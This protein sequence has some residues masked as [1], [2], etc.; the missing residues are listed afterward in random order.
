MQDV[1]MNN[2]VKKILLR[3]CREPGYVTI[4]SI[5]KELEV[6]TKTV[7]RELAEVESWLESKGCNLSKKTGTG[8]KVNG[9]E[10]RRKTILAL[11]MGEKEENFYSPR[12]RQIV[13][14]SELLQNQ[15][16]VK[17]YNFA[18]ILKVTEGTISN[19]L[20]KIEQWFAKQELTLV[21]RPGLGVYVEGPESQLRKA[22]VH[23]IYENIEEDQLLGIIRSSLIQS[24]E[25]TA[26]LES[27]TR[28]RLLNLI[29]KN[30]IHKLEAS[31]HEAQEKMGHR[32]AD[33]AYVGLIVHLAL[34]VQRIRKKEKITIDSEF[35]KELKEYPEYTIAGQM[36]E[37]IAQNFGI[38]LPE[39]EI[40]YITMHIKG[41]KNRNDYK[42]DGKPIGNFELVKLSKEII[43]IAERETGQLL[44]HN[45]KLLVGLVNHL[46]PS[47]SR[48]KMGLDIRN[49]FVE[50]IKAFYPDLVEISRRCAQAVEDKLGLPMP[51][52]EIAYIA[53]HLGAAMETGTNLPKPL[54]RCA[55]ACSTG[56]GTSRLL[57]TKLEKEFDNLQIVELISTIHLEEGRLQEQQVDFIISTVS[58]EPCTL[59][60]VTVNPLLFEEDKNK[61]LSLMRRLVSKMATQP[62]K[63]RLQLK[64]RLLALEGYSQA[65]IALLDGFF[66]LEAQEAQQVEQIIDEVSDYLGEDRGQAAQLAQALKDREEK[67]G[68]FITGHGLVLL[69]C[70]SS[71]VKQ[72]CFGAVQIRESL[73]GINGLGETEAVNLAVIMTAPEG[74]GR[75]GMET[76]G[77][78]SKMLLERPEFTQ[79]LRQGSRQEASME[80]TRILEEFYRMKY[81]KLMEGYT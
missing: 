23:F 9:S 21:R 37:R 45:E 59:P 70:R 49:P 61:I 31:I 80:V 22:M 42:K 35:L 43:R 32:L 16:P 72:L 48:L 54:Y 55:V 71:A 24:S 81:K 77:Y 60:V 79:L 27:T 28:R 52:S 67:G 4:S 30:I 8:I 73:F 29:D 12:E 15:E 65:V 74:T 38:E 18:R 2:R 50:E 46:G 78:L 6:S 41:S 5:A 20:D 17:L 64:E 26:D 19:D 47:I 36:A 58:I 63:D 53:M 1:K 57:A 39:S 51:E 40:G 75:Q 25:P 3:I 13:I 33:S 69:H 10:D 7:I 76:I 56:I 14:I 66:L 62:G 34:A 68:T 44:G 11:L